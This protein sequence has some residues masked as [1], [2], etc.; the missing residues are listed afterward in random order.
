MVYSVVPLMVDLAMQKLC[1]HRTF[2]PHDVDQMLSILGQRFGLELRIGHPETFQHVE[3]GI[4][5]RL[6]VCF[7]SAD[8]T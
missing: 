5:N 1:G 8:R 6:R 7:P 2:Y 3:R 4:T